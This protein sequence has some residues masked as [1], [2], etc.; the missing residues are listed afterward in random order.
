MKEKKPR[1]VKKPDLNAPRFAKHQFIYNVVN[2]DL[3]EQW[4]KETGYTLSF[5]QFEDV[6]AKITEVIRTQVVE[7]THGVRLPFF[8][9]DL[10]TNYVNMLNSVEKR[11]LSTQLGYS[12]KPLNWHSGGKPGKVC[13]SI[14][15][16]RRQHRR[17]I[18]FAFNP[19]RIFSNLAGEGFLKHPEVYRYARTTSYIG[20]KQS[21]KND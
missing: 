3:H 20:Y 8:N 10:V 15:H 14:N 18:L 9:G 7:N 5:K 13:W 16:A 11:G 2:K 12:V 1:T 6:W 21:L 17:L 4:Q 19:C